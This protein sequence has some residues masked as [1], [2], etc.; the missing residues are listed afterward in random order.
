MK[1]NVMAEGRDHAVHPG[2]SLNMSGFSVG[3][4]VELYPNP[5]LRSFGH[6]YGRITY[7]NQNK[8]NA[9]VRLWGGATVTVHGVLLDYMRPIRIQETLAAVA[10]LTVFVA[11]CG[12]FMCAAIAAFGDALSGYAPVGIMWRSYFFC[13]ALFL[14]GWWFYGRSPIGCPRGVFGS[15]PLGRASI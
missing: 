11:I 3:Q 10:I 5:R 12:L 4:H 7:V 15:V 2:L 1:L 13:C 9:S 6:F 14:V 8:Q